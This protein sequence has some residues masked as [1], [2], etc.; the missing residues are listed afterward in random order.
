MV[1]LFSTDL[2]RSNL[3]FM[4]VTFQS[5]DSTHFARY[6]CVMTSLPV[7]QG[8]WSIDHSHT[9]IGFTVRHLGLNVVRG[10]FRSFDGV[11]TIGDSLATSNV[12]MSI[13]ASSIETNDERRGQTLISEGWFDAD[14]FPFV[15]FVSSG[16]RTPTPDDFSEFLLDGVLTVRGVSQPVTLDA[17]FYGVAFYPPTKNDHVGFSAR[18]TVDRRDFGFVVELPLEGGRLGI[19]NKVA[20][21]IEAQWV[22]E[23]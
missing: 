2:Q 16:V 19:A 18:T 14:R 8:R 5:V 11:L 1:I 21:E 3:P 22:P 9:W 7:A 17:Q 20:I 6:S 13:S 15:T 10:S 4:E 12:E 23:P